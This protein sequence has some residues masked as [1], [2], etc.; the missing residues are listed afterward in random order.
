MGI[1]NGTTL[2][3][4]S[5]GPEQET[6]ASVPARALPMIIELFFA[7]IIFNSLL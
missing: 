1:V 3:F 4:S 5:G 7:F 2:K 6:I